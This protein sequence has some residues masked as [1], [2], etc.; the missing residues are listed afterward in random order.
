MKA[1]LDSMARVFSAVGFTPEP[2]AHSPSPALP[3]LTLARL[4]EGAGADA[5]CP[6]AWPSRAPGPGGEPAPT[7]WSVSPSDTRGLFTRSIHTIPQCTARRAE[8]R[9][10]PVACGPR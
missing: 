6:P 10:G 1:P 9:P 8:P 3:G 5:G 2:V 7:L 4:P